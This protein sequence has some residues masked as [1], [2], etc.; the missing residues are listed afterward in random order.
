MWLT[1]TTPNLSGNSKI[2]YAVITYI[3]AGIIYTG[4][5]TA[6]TS[7]LPNLTTHASERII[8]NTF[9]MTGGAIGAFI[10]MT[11]TLPLVGLFGNGNEH[12]VSHL[13][14]L[15][16]VLLLLLCSSLPLSIFMK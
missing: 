12:V 13:P 15:F 10:C 9:R 3:F 14:W 16:L 1:F 8:L 5:Q 4:I 2:I 6:I 11:F 7:I